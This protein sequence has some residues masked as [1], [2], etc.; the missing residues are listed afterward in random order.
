M[1]SELI[2]VNEIYIWQYLYNESALYQDASE[3]IT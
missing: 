1:K 2:K 3:S